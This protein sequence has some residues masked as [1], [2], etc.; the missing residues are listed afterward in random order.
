MESLIN[1][2]IY[3]WDWFL[4]N[5]QPDNLAAAWQF[6]LAYRAAGGK[7]YEETESKMKKLLPEQAQKQIRPEKSS[8]KVMDLE[9]NLIFGYSHNQIAAMQGVKELR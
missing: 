1:K 3:Y 8:A 5:S 9:E 7:G 6:M 2:S 4:I